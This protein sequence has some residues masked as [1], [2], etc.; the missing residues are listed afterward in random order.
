VG[1]LKTVSIDVKY[2]NKAP[3]A[4]LLVR[5]VYAIIFCIAAFILSIVGGIAWALQLLVILITGTR[6][7][8]LHDVILF[9]FKYRTR[10]SA[11][12]FFLTDEQPPVIPEGN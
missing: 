7:R 10:F 11:Y 3:R 1:W 9:V 12:L 5:I 6:N 2:A 4:E 8:A